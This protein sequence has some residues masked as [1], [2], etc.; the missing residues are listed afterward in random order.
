[1][2]LYCMLKSIYIYEEVLTTFGAIVYVSNRLYRS[3][4]LLIVSKCTDT[5][6]NSKIAIFLWCSKMWCYLALQICP[7][8]KT[9][10]KL[11]RIYIYLFYLVM[12]TT[13]VASTYTLYC[14]YIFYYIITV[15]WYL[16]RALQFDYLRTLPKA[17]NGPSS[18]NNLI[19][20]CNI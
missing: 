19:Y 6:I 17:Y 1:M 3:F 5:D 8:L 7:V 11:N 16:C 14:F 4:F 13:V 15:I 2:K 9:V 12:V 20:V 10:F 18:P